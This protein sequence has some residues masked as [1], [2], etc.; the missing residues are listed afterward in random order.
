MIK[1]QN[2]MRKFL[3]I[4]TAIILSIF[5]AIGQDYLIKVEMN[6]KKVHAIESV[7][8]FFK[9]ESLARIIDKIDTLGSFSE[10]IFL[11]MWGLPLTEDF[12][13]L[14]VCME[15]DN[16]NNLNALFKREYVKKKIESDSYEIILSIIKIDAQFCTFPIR[17]KLWPAYAANF[18]TG[19]VLKDN[20]SILKMKKEDKQKIK[21]LFELFEDKLKA[22]DNG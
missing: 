15:S 11:S 20:Y 17:F 18:Y 13:V 3:I 14:D 2:N 9:A 22:I 8:M 1:Y 19:G 21:K 5:N 10:R 4:F 7:N 12:Y 16:C 6:Y